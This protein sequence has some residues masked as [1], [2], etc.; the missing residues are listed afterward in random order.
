MAPVAVPEEN[1][2]EH[3]ENTEQMGDIGV[4]QTVHKDGTVDYVDTHAIGGDLEKMPDG[5]FYSAQFIGTVTVSGI[6]SIT[7]GIYSHISGSLLCQ[8]LRL[9]RMGLASKHIVRLLLHTFA[10][11]Y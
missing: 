7:R 6:Q 11:N 2:L 5:Y 9:S 4:V 1:V 8:Y 3:R 10:N